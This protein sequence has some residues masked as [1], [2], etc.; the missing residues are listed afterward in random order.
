LCNISARKH[1][2]PTALGLGQAN[3]LSWEHV[4]AQV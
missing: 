1:G 4:G 3:D 2:F